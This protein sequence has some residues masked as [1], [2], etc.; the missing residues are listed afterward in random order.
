MHIIGKGRYRG[1]TYPGAQSAATGALRNRK[2]ADA[3]L[4]VAPFT[5]SGNF[6]AATLFTPKVSGVIQVSAGISLVNGATPDD[7][8]AVALVVPGTGLSVTGGSTTVDGWVMGSTVPPVVG[9]LLGTPSPIGEA[10]AAVAGNA[11]GTLLCFGI[12]SP[13]QVGIPVVITVSLNSV[14]G[15]ALTTIAIVNLS[16]L[17]LP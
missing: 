13:L 4:L 16:V 5:P 3:T 11:T 7:Y 9:G 2:V 8:A 14:G 12:S 6:V 15:S 10:V 1:E 17:E